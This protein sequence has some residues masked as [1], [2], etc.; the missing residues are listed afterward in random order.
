MKQWPL[1]VDGEWA[2]CQKGNSKGYACVEWL[3]RY[4]PLNAYK[5]PVRYHQAV[6][7]CGDEAAGHAGDGGVVP[8]VLLPGD[9]VAVHNVQGQTADVNIWQGK[10]ILQNSA[11][12]YTPFQNLKHALP[13]RSDCRFYHLLE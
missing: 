2:L 7:A 5:H 9:V 8:S 6:G 13:E 10:S 12:E 4:R 1:R 3:R 11:F